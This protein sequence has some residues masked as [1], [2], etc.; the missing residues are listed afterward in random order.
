M[1]FPTNQRPSPSTTR[2]LLIAAVLIG[3]L[4]YF[5]QRDRLHS[6][7][8]ASGESS[9]SSSLP[10]ADNFDIVSRAFHDRLNNVQVMSEGTVTRVLA[11]DN[12]GSRHQR[13]LLRLKSGQTV[14]IAHNIDVAPR[15]TDLRPGD[16]VAF[17]GEYE[18]NER[19]GVVHWTH[20]DPS[21]NH[22]PGWLRFDGKV[23]Q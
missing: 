4:Q 15:V 7:I 19:G 8:P 14:L 17:S 9:E 2:W 21:G 6:A 1:R 13:F 12:E 5:Q 16:N 20:K 11:D 3:G 18:W 23:Y 10:T 22:V